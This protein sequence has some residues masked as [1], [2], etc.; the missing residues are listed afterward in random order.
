M[1]TNR[2]R[3]F[4]G[5]IAIA[6]ASAIAPRV[7]RPQTPMSATDELSLLR[8]ATIREQH[9][10]FAAAEQIY[11]RVLR[12]NPQS[13]SALLAVE[14]VLRLEGKLHELVPIVQ[15]HLKSDPSSAIGHQ[16][17]VR[18]YSSLDQVP[19]L[20]KA[21]EAWMRATPK[22]ETP[23]REIARAWQLRGD[24]SRAL[25][26]LEI[27]R[28]RMGSMYALA[29]ELGDVYAALE[30]YPRAV[31]E[32]DKAIG[33]DA[34][35]LLLVQRRLTSMKD[36]GAQ[37]LPSLI[38]ALTR[39]PTT[40]QRRR[41]AGIL[42]IDAGLNE[43]AQDIVRALAGEMRG[44][45][46]QNFLVEMARRAD[47]AQLPRVAF[48]AYSQVALAQLNPE[49]SL[50]VRARLAEL[51]LAT[52]D[53]AGAART[54]RDLELS[55]GAGSPQRRQAVAVRIQLIIKEGKLADA[56][57]EL[58]AFRTEYTAAPELDALAAA[59][60]NSY[61]DRD[62]PDHADRVL[63]GA[64]GPR[65]NVA[66]GRIALRKGDINSAKTALMNAA[67]YLQGAEA[68]QTIRLVTMLGKVSKPGGELLGKAMARA[69]AGAPKEA[70]TMLEKGSAVLP[71]LERP[72]MLDFAAAIADRSE[73]PLDAE[74][75][76]R[77]IITDY[78]RS[79]EAPAAL[80]A[81]ARSLTERG[82]TPEEARQYLEK[83]ILE[84]PKSALVPQAR[85][86]L[87]RLQG[88]VPRS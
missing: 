20:E 86:E 44:M 22:L 72:A 88:R 1:L 10:D 45:E 81:L 37:I 3:L 40:M 47:A 59:L 70:F 16:M 68:M 30:E 46:R 12:D 21:G 66:R 2:S 35:G 5:A 33:P 27:G 36:G 50:A 71:V 23:Y 78:P 32:W 53:T 62:D 80:L 42:A 9:G 17:L 19:D 11:T 75:M 29:L 84:Y 85:Q 87:D 7:A 77:R 54:F 79:M 31:R 76:R 25:Q 67:P 28:Q 58:N 8:D 48:W 69:G 43:R 39:A 51:A 83:L 41:A 61:L 60:A 15:A 38:D 13:L 49:Q 57:N 65:S 4:A 82:E 14:R 73:M 24:Y 26:Y 64:S 55:L 52:G 63:A 34:R 74:R 56:E 18:A 6:I